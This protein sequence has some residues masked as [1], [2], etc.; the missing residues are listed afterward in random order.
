MAAGAERPGRR[1]ERACRAESPLLVA[2]DAATRELFETVRKVAATRLSVLV[3]GESG[4]GKEV[5]AREIHRA[6]G[7]PGPFVAVNVA[8][9]AESLAEAELFGAARGAYTGAERDRAGVLEASSGGTLFLDEIG[10][11]SPRIQAKLLRVLQ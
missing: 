11:L 9:F 1:E 7:R 10:D 6:S 8:A 4:T 5:V 3:L 2:E